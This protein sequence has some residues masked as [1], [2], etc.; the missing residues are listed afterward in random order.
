MDKKTLQYLIEHADTGETLN[1]YAH[2][3]YEDAKE[4]VR[5]IFNL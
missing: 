3:G 2:L 4:K 5:K 1:T